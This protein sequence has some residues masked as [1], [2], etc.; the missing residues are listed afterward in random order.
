MTIKEIFASMDYGKAPESTDKASSWYAERDNTLLHYIDGKWQQPANGE[1]FETINPANGEVLARVAD[2]ADQDTN[3]AVAAASAAA[4]GWAGLSGHQRARYL[5]AIARQV[6]KHSRL[7]SVFA[8]C[9]W[10]GL[11]STA[12]RSDR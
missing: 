8:V 10:H 7:F 3:R 5:Y 2:G 12:H 1:F 6:Q 4:S 9:S 11:P